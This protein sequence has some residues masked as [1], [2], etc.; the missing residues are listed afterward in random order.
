RQ[1]GGRRAPQGSRGPAGALARASG[2]IGTWSYDLASGATHVD[3]RFA[4]LFQ[5]DAVLAREG[6]ELARFTDMIHP[7]DRPRVLA[8]IEHAI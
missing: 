2:N 3:E 8:A 5:A 1:D 4:R 6:T 7:D